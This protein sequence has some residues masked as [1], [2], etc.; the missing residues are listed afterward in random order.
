MAA[1]NSAL[2]SIEIYL[3]LK[4]NKIKNFIVNCNVSQYYSFYIYAVLVSVRDFW[5][6]DQG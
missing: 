4:Y 3:I 2:L 6:V 1:R 5:S